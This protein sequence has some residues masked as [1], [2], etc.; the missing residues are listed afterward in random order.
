MRGSQQCP[1]PPPPHTR[2]HWGVIP[3]HLKHMLKR[4]TPAEMRWWVAHKHLNGVNSKHQEL[5]LVRE[6][7]AGAGTQLTSCSKWPPYTVLGRASPSIN[8]LAGGHSVGAVAVT[9]RA[10]R[11]LLPLLLHWTDWV[12][13]SIHINKHSLAGA[14]VIQVSLANA[15]ILEQALGSGWHRSK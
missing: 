15:K 10:W 5:V 13:R 4:D 6:R 7:L 14:F 1:A 12:N 3:T 2:W 8:A 9:P 11:L